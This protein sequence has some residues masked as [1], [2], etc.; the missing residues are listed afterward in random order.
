M[1]KFSSSPDGLQ[2]SKYQSTANMDA[3]NMWYIRILIDFLVIVKRQGCLPRTS[4]K[5]SV[6]SLDVIPGEMI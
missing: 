3:V 5:F 4:E 6:C 1:P 2:A